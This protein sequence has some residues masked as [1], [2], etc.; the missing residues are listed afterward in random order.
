MTGKTIRIFLPDGAPTGMLVAEVGNWTGKVFVVPRA[1]LGDLAGRP[2]L[3]CPGVYLLAGPDPEHPARDLVYV[4]E[5]ED[6]LRRLK[7][8]HAFDQSKD[9]WSRAAVVISKDE[10]LTKVHVKY[11][12]NRLMELVLA[13]GRA[14]RHN[15]KASG[16]PALPEA[17]V[18]DVETFLEH[19]QL[20]LPVVGLSFTVQRPVV[21]TGKPEAAAAG[22]EGTAAG[23]P[24]G[25]SPVF[26]LKKRSGARARMQLVNEGFVVFKGSLARRVAV[27]SLMYY[28]DLR[29][30]LID[31]GKLVGVSSGPDLLEF[32]ENVT[33]SSPTAAA[34]VIIGVD[35]TGLDEWREEGGTRRFRDWQQEQLQQGEQAAEP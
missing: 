29:A 30:Q 16:R 27:P 3:R 34:T 9:F 33:F 23:V 6:V 17:D 21:G 1:Q 25:A 24:G 4:G 7:D 19:I 22:A 8:E 35:C 32:A 11:L 5:S 20:V 13:A 15:G 12:E 10:N 18:A 31:E 14:R 2:E 28:K 26:F